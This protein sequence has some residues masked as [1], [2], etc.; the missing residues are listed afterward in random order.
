M[1][2]VALS[3]PF[4]DAQI[5]FLKAKAR[6]MQEEMER[7]SEELASEKEENNKLTSRIKELEDERNKLS[8]FVKVL[9]RNAAYNV[10]FYY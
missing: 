7:L 3:L 6:V 8:R 5:R 9:L 1:I 4:V 2:T 10:V